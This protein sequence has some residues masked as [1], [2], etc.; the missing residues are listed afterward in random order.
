MSSKDDQ[1]SSADDDVPTPVLKPIFGNDDDDDNDGMLSFAD[2]FRDKVK[3][4]FDHF[5]LDR[6]GFLQY[7][8]LRALQAATDEVVLSEDMY[9]MACKA[10]NCHPKQGI[11]LEAL[12]FTYASEGADIDKDYAKV[13]EKKM[14]ET[15]ST[16][17]DGNEEEEQE[18]QD[19]VYEIGAGGVD[20]S[21]KP[22]TTHQKTKPPTIKSPHPA[23][24]TLETS[25][26]NNA[27]VIKALNNLIEY[28]KKD[29][30]CSQD[31]PKL[32]H[33]RVIPN[34]VQKAYT[35]IDNGA[36]MVHSTATKYTLVGKISLTD[37]IKLGTDL[38]RGCELIGA[39][40]H[41]LLQDATGCCRAVRKLTQRASLAIFINVLHL[42]QSFED[43][44]AMQGNVGAQK[45]G[46]VWEACDQILNKMLPKGNRNAIRR[47]LFT[48]TQEINDSMEEF[49]E[50]LDMGPCEA[51][52]DMDGEDEDD[53]DEDD[54]FGGDEQYNDNDFP[55]ATACLGL[56]KNSRGNMKIA[57]EICELLGDKAGE[58]EGDD[59]LMAILQIHKYAREIGEGATDFG[60]LMY[61][62]LQE[63]VEELTSQFQK[64]VQTIKDLQSFILGLNGIPSRISELSNILSSAADTRSG[65]FNT[66]IGG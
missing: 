36:Q 58:T 65:E 21:K 27:M 64:Q 25:T 29:T 19:V 66:A 3:L 44:S 53:Y 59:H 40:L 51:P 50:L 26:S 4:L 17:A 6:D 34:E 54:L 63:K 30:A 56:L 11:S 1:Q 41:I 43:E 42:V 5:D 23:S 38:L 12:K 61:P 62:P 49:Q 7:D 14:E 35:L 48:W 22:Q 24:A 18:D 46:A 47:E 8:E 57:L 39:S 37:Q 60:S 20:I 16:T 15:T 9:V 31:P 32:S 55:I 33:Y 13:F 52:G 45:T 28:V 10:L 2:G